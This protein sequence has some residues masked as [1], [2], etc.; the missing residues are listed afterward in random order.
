MIDFSEISKKWQKK[1]E[2]NKIFEANPDKRK[3][4]FINFPY[5]YINSY[6]HL[7]HAFS[8]TRVD[9]FARYK[10]MQG[11]NVL[12][13]QAW[14]CTGTPVWAAAQRIKE[15]E[16]KQIK[17]LESLGFTG[18][19]I[20][21]FSDVKHWIDVF[22]PAA[23]QD[24]GR[25]G[26]SVDWRRSFITTDLN[27]RYDKFIRWQFGKLKEKGLIDKG[28]H[29][30]VWCP[31]DK[32]PIGDHD[33]VEGEGE[34]PKDFIWV[35]F[36]LKNSDLVLMVGTTRPD[37]LLGQTHIWVD[38][39]ATYNIVKVKDEK[40]V[41]GQEAVNK[42]EDQ[43]KKP[44]VIGT[45]TSKELIG[46]WAKGPLV[47]YELYIAPAWFID[48]NVGSGIV[49]S[50]L[51][52]P[53][54]LAE[55]QHIQAHPEIVKKYNLDEEVIRKLKPI[56]IINVPGMGENLGQEMIDKYKIKSPQDKDKIE[57]AK[58]ELNRTVFRKGVMKN[59]CGKYAGLS[60]PKAQGVI[61]NDLIEA[62]D[63]VMFYELTGKVVCRCL[64]ECT[65]KMVSDQWFLKYGDK[66]WKEKVRKS[67]AQM[68]LYPELVRTN[69]EHVI[70]WLNDWA[71]THLHGTGTK[72]PWDE[73][74]VI[75]SLSDSTI[76]MAYY[77]IAHL[78]KE[79]PEDEIDDGL[80]DYIFL[81]NE[82]GGEKN[83]N[84][85]LMKK[86]FEYWYPFDVRSSGK[87]LIQNHLTFCLFNH[88]AIFPE[89]YWPKA[90]SVNGWLLV[91]GDKMSKSK[92]NFYTIREIIG[93][94]SAD[95]TRAG[96]VLG[97]EGLSDPNFDLNNA[98]SVGEKLEQW[99]EFAAKNY[100]KSSKTPLSI[101]DR[102]LLSGIHRSLKEGT[103][104]MDDMLFRTAFEKLFF[105]MQRL[106]KEYIKRKE[107]N[108]HLLNEFIE[109]QTKVLSPFCPFVSE[110]IWNLLGK[111]D[112][113]S[114]SEWPKFN[115]KLI[116]KEAEM[117]AQITD[118]A[119][120]DIIEILKLT[121]IGKASKIT[122]FV[123]EKWKYE[124]VKMLR[125]VLNETR[126]TG[127]ILKKLMATSLKPHGAEISKM[128]PRLVN[129]PNR[130]PQLELK[131]EAELS[132]L[133]DAV[134]I[135]ESEFGCK[136]E[137]ALAEKSDEAKARQS[138][139]GK[140][141]ILVK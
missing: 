139:P 75:E 85:Q 47:D 24:L 19:E 44:E 16:P 74:W 78:I 125:E 87:D 60:V 41:V 1:W 34:T 80:F 63:A 115:E 79:I 132:A 40:W 105:Q 25:L 15:N 10:R 86:E 113:V 92:G 116:D 110:E 49:Y 81:G 106:L 27:P 17:I 52:D 54:D 89:K 50:A 29:P 141:A 97:G 90:F 46:K 72:L 112:F 20:K 67:L 111:K 84:L 13:P 14:H 137:I 6:L 12:F 133:K 64:T 2:E 77:T 135:Y 55:I 62:N 98:K 83:K 88:T 51:E 107:I 129:D 131:Q 43:Y 96:L 9:V 102:I 95:V 26:A 93:L 136:I 82:N 91:E 21:K 103:E 73:K 124:F 128:V 22:V 56:S 127:D 70:A 76:Y 130:I 38:P 58:G 57:E 31:K 4:F 32:M 33:R 42:I 126:N 59:N 118:T 69:F 30:V 109:I 122:L 99:L 123:P 3:K 48:A 66:K 104:A 18:S 140:A 11:Y 120:K 45:I 134:K 39:D 36:R 121:K 138:F 100:K 101:A 114:I 8:V 5:P 53:V 94:Y 35:K 23:K 68:R 37:A 108:Q 117:I 71:C 7:G 28:S 119:R 65:I 61:N